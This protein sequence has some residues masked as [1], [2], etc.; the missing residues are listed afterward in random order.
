MPF[1][2]TKGSGSASFLP[3]DGICAGSNERSKVGFLFR[4]AS[5]SHMAVS[6]RWMMFS[7]SSFSSFI[8]PRLQSS[9]EIDSIICITFPAP[10]T[11]I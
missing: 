6:E 7:S 11:C 5:R 1:I 10:S 8:I 9:Q 3:P 2:S 4:A